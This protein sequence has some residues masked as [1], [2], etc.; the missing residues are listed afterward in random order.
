MSSWQSST[1][2]Q[3]MSSQT[4]DPEGFSEVFFDTSVLLDYTL[5]QDDGTAKELLKTHKSENYTGK[6][7]EREFE[8]I[9]ERREKIIKSIYK[10]D[11]LSEWDVPPDVDMSDNDQSWCA[12]LL[13]ELDGL[14]SRE[15]LED[16]L[17]REERKFSRGYDQLFENTGKLITRV[18]PNNLDAQLL[19]SLHF[20]EN[21]NDK[22]VVCESADWATE[23]DSDSLIT[24]DSDDLLSQRDRISQ[25]VN[26]NRDVETLTIFNPSDFLE[27]D[28]SY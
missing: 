11:D 5:A 15:D 28:P 4:H 6:T 21:R 25:E 3:K 14:A 1:G 27:E 19:A 13:A 10:C 8:D 2:A 24:T 16:R 22:Q 7:P 18:W 12:E 23:V 17:D 20:I 26:R 9:K